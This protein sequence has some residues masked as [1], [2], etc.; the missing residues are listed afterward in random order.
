MMLLFGCSTSKIPCSQKLQ[1]IRELQSFEGWE[2][3]NFI[4]PKTTNYEKCEAFQGKSPFYR[5]KLATF[6]K[7]MIANSFLLRL[8]RE[9]VRPPKYGHASEEAI[10]PY[11]LCVWYSVKPFA[12]Q[13]TTFTWLYNIL[14]NL[15]LYIFTYSRKKCNSAKISFKIEIFLQ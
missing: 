8:I 15:Q 13:H 9:Y 14:L 11:Q 5:A 6:M 4:M 7:A 12:N 3:V 1:F 10:V 2:I